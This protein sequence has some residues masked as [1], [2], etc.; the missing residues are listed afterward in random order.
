M[1]PISVVIADDLP[2]VVDAL[3]ELLGGDPSIV[4][5][6]TANDAVAAVEAAAATRPDVALL[7]VRMPAG[8]GGVAAR[9][10]R[11]VSP[12]PRS[13]RCRR[14]SIVRQ[15]SRWCAPARSAT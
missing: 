3:T 10:I 11:E 15:S 14:S 2:L 12:T 8:G 7:D 4:V 6:A 13:S 9:G 1:T 5:V